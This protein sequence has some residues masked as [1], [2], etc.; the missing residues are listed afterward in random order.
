MPDLA[1]D[2]AVEILSPGNTARE[3]ERK[4]GEYFAAG[5]RIVWV[6]SPTERAVRVYTGP[7]D[8]RLFVEG[9][10]LDAAPVLP[11]FR[12]AIRD[13]FGAAPPRQSA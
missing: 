13:W 10:T 2:L 8:A 12:L 3:M 1:P 5:T 4:I 9:D 6:V 7:A 11:G